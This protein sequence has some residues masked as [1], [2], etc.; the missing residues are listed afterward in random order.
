M[1]ECRQDERGAR[2]CS[3]LSKEEIVMR[4]Q[5]LI[6]AGLLALL[7]ANAFA[8]QGE[9][10]ALL[11]ED[12]ARQFAGSRPKV[13]P[14]KIDGSWRP[15]NAQIVV[16]EANI[17]QLSDPVRYHKPNGETITHPEEYFRQYLAVVRGGQKLIYVDA[18]C[19]IRHMPQWRT[20]LYFHVDGRDGCYWSAWYDPA[21][22]KFIELFI[23]RSAVDLEQ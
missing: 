11:P 2:M 19:D 15:S 16:L 12:A 22:G 9:R 13:G 18:F 17:M 1:G 3:R 4:V 7:A 21:T 14:Q 5:R 8:Q 20:H 10:Y 6:V 23:D